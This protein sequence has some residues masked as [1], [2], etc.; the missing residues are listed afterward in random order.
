MASMAC[1]SDDL[2]NKAFLE[3]KTQFEIENIFQ[4]QEDAM[5]AFFEK[6]NV[7]V[8]LPTGYGKSLVFQCLPIVADVLYERPGG[9]SVLV[10]ISPLQSLMEDQV[11]CLGNL[12]I[13]AVAIS[14][15]TDAEIIQ[16]VVNGT[17]GLVFGSPECFLS[18]AIWKGVLNTPSFKEALVGV[19]IDEAHCIT[20]WG[21]S[22]SKKVP[23]RKW[24][25][26]LGELRGSLPYSG[27]VN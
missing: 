26:C 5:K 24:Y 27:P 13:P 8:N 14:N 7:F 23:F 4:E 2:W 6:G 1:F 17:F 21:L 10:V 25:G 9:T 12:G 11:M 19:A 22:G 3:V 15:E 20:Q 18:T 16:Q